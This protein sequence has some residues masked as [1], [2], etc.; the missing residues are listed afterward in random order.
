VCSRGALKGEGAD[1]G[2]PAPSASDARGLGF[3]VLEEVGVLA[4]LGGPGDTAADVEL[5][6]KMTGC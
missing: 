6:F 4:P 2:G 3:L 5:I 1:A